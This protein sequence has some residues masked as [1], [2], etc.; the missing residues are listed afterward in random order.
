MGVGGSQASAWA[1][2]TLAEALASRQPLRGPQ[3]WSCLMAGRL[4]SLPHLA[5]EPP[6]PGPLAR[7]RVGVGLGPALV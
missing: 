1:A 3:T 7:G 6:R 5:W 4:F 2:G